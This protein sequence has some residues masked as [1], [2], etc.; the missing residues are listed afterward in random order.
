M[1]IRKKKPRS[2]QFDPIDLE[3][4]WNRLI[5]VVDEAAYAVIRTSMSKVVV[6]G[7]DFSAMLFDPRGNQL[8]ADVSIASKTGTVSISVREMLKRFP[9]E[10]IRPG[11]MFVTNNP[12]FINGHLNDI[13]VVAP[14][15]HHRRLIGFAECM[16]HMADIG[17]CLS[18]SPREV[19]EEGI[20]IPPLKIVEGGKENA[21]L[22][23]IVGAN[24]RT[25]RQILSDI[26]ALM[27]GVQV[28]D[29]KVCEYLDQHELDDLE[30]LG[31][32]IRDHSEAAMRRGIAASIPDGVYHGEATCEGAAAPL[33]IKVTLTVRNGEVHMDFDGSSPQSHIGINCTLPYTRVWCAYTIKCIAMPHLPNN[34]GTF[35]PIHVA[36][37]EGSFLNPKFPAPVRMK[38]S[39]GHY[40]PD[41]IIDAVKNVVPKTILAE[42]GNKFLVDFHGRTDDGRP[43]AEV[44]FVMGGMGARATKDGPHCMSFPANSSN[45][46]V[47][48]LE[49]TVPVRVRSKTLRPDSGGPGRY[50]G[51]CGQEFVFES[52]SPSPL[53]V[54]AVHGKLAT[55]PNGLRGGMAGAAGGIWV[56]DRPVPDKTPR[57]LKTGDV[58]RLSVPGG[59]GMY[60]PEERHADALRRDVENGVVTDEGARQYASARPKPTPGMKAPVEHVAE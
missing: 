6:E 39:S 52:V 40:I 8:A 51:G 59:G 13:A 26:R 23:E 55:G 15:F 19:Y 4:L 32:A 20:F 24:V 2:V 38:P 30:S 1:A 44:I 45:I 27:V 18:A 41:A 58:M 56:N 60:A 12:W 25:P 54:R 3:V 10:S 28:M 29:A 49:A 11:D 16:A 37:P 7:R 14:I 33:L 36:A 48:V 21:T 22:F 46:P 57:E 9:A 53:T 17:G 47:E 5:T 50:R 35:A 42:S 34:D 31:R 43:V